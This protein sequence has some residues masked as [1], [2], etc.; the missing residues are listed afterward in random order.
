MN[1]N[2][3]NSEDRFYV[4][5]YRS[6]KLVAGST[7]LAAVVVATSVFASPTGSA[8]PI[9]GVVLALLIMGISQFAVEQYHVLD[10]EEQ[11]VVLMTELGPWRR[12][13][14]VRKFGNISAVVVNPR[15][16]LWSRQQS[17]TNP[18]SAWTHDGTEIVLSNEGGLHSH[19]YAVSKATAMAERIGCDLLY[20]EAEMPLEVTRR[21]REIQARAKSNDVGPLGRAVAV[22]AVAG[23][24]WGMVAHMP[25]GHFDLTT[26]PA[27]EPVVV[28]VPPASSYV[29]NVDGSVVAKLGE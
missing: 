29:Q 17:W 13:Q 21:G 20:G 28:V 4:T 6:P 2:E 19:E 18:V 12:M 23:L 24:V 14:W 9:L 7:V 3:P 25:T 5:F 26:E 11:D 15:P 1:N 10:S 22:C 8:F 16:N 27:P